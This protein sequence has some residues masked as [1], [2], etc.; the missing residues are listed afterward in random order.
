MVYGRVEPK[1]V[2]RAG[3]PYD[4]MQLQDDLLRG[5]RDCGQ[6]VRT[7]FVIGAEI[8]SMELEGSVVRQGHPP[9]S[10]LIAVEDD[11]EVRVRCAEVS[12]DDGERVG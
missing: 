4:E 7:R 6:Q 11:G 5:V 3:R 2:V 12:G 8:A 1:V 10:V 9:R